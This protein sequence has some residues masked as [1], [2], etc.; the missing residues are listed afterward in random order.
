MSSARSTRPTP[1]GA[2]PCSTG[3]GSSLKPAA[4]KRLLRPFVLLGAALASACSPLQALNRSDRLL[5]SGGVRMVAEGIAFGADP[6]Q[7]LDIYAPAHAAH[8]P[9]IVF[10]YGGS[11]ASGRRQDY[12]FAA[13]AFASR[14]FVVVV[15]D[16]RLVPSV[17]FPAFIEDG[18]AAVGWTARHI[19]GYGGDP[20]RLALAGHSAGAYVAVILAVDRRWLDAAHV[21]PKAIRAVA[22][23][24]GPY[25]FYPFDKPASIA[26]FGQAAHPKATQPINFARADAPPAFLA[27]G[28]RDDTVRPRNSIRMAAALDG[29]GAPA[30]LRLY[31]KLDHIGILLALSRP[32]RGKAPVVDDIAGFLHD[33]MG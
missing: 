11:W 5:G 33:K 16:Y 31:P 26:A 22:G 3:P 21:D 9:V 14:G 7:R 27:H 13:R 6:R 8:A 25:D 29:A 19:G 17:R 23:L 32:F 24:A 1:R 30:T 2:M 12:G 18:A 4:V 10:F 20:S 15:P 28:E